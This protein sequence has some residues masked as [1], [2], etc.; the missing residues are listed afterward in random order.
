MKKLKF[1]Y[2]EKAKSFDEISH[3]ALFREFFEYWKKLDLEKTIVGVFDS[4]LRLSKEEYFQGTVIKKR[5]LAITENLYII[6][7]IT[8][9][10]MDKGIIK[11]L[12]SVGADIVKPKGK[13]IELKKVKEPDEKQREK[14]EEI[15]HF[16]V[17]EK[18]GEGKNAMA[19]LIT[20][21]M[22]EREEAIKN[23]LI[24]GNPPN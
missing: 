15:V 19:D 8:P 16:I 10:A 9:Q 23:R 11:F 6:T 13:A 2:N 21:K 3:A 1:K 17:S 20:L 18:D 12:N 14:L 22:K 7:H 5:N 24:K 4:D